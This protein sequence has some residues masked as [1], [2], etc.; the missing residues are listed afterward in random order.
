MRNFHY[1]I[2]CL[3]LALCSCKKQIE[4]QILPFDK[5]YIFECNYALTDESE[6]PYFEFYVAGFCELDK[7]FNLQNARRISYDIYKHY[8]ESVPDSM[9]NKISDILSRYQSDTTFLYKGELGSRIYDGNA[10]RF[11]MQ[12][13]NQKDITIKFEPNFLPEDLKFV[14]SYLCESQWAILYEDKFSK[15]FEM[16]EN[17][18]KSEK[19]EL[20]LKYFPPR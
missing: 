18:T 19:D 3:L 6:D 12:K 5:L 11:I 4:K 20:E 9:R 7:D 8:V 15:L 13:H 1:I 17:Q 2:F 16:F 10:Y 14:Y